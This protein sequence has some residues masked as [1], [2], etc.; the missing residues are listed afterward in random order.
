MPVRIDE[1]VK[2]CLRKGPIKVF[3]SPTSTVI[4]G[5]VLEGGVMQAAAGEVQVGDI[6]ML[7]IVYP[8]GAVKLD[9]VQKRHLREW[10]GDLSRARDDL[11]RR[12]V[13]ASV[14]DGFCPS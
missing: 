10:E 5:E 3:E 2:V 8:A 1:F 11:K 13:M 14:F 12:R 6:M 9:Y 4:V 7:P